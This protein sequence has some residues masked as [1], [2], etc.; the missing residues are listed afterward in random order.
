MSVFPDVYAGLF[1]DDLD[2]VGDRLDA[3][4]LGPGATDNPDDDDALC[5]RQDSTLC[6]GSWLSWLSSSGSSLDI[7]RRLALRSLAVQARDVVADAQSAEP[8]Q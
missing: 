4:V 6:T 5:P 1:G 7:G 3:T 8:V 2:Q